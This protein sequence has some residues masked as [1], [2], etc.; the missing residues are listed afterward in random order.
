[1]YTEATLLVALRRREKDAF[2]YL[3]D[4]YADKI[5]RV[6]A[7]V[8]QDDVE[9]ECVVQDTFL[10]FFERL[11]QFEGRAALSTWL[12]RIAYNA[13]VDRLRRRRPVSDV[14]DE[15]AASLVVPALL[16]DWSDL[17]EQQLSKAEVAEE[18]ERAIASL[19]DSYRIV[20]VLREVEGLSTEETAE[21][22]GISPANVKVRLHRARLLLRESLS[23]SLADRV[24]E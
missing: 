14:D 15:S 12:Y 1:M 20:F 3:F 5:F 8:L 2:K 23:A 7:G 24:T 10:R 21:I 17:P 18:L 6:A 4:T 9:A 13:A 22:A 19:P 16:V 11:E